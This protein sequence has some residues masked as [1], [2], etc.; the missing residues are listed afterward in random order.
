VKKDILTISRVLRVLKEIGIDTNS[1]NLGDS[2][3]TAFIIPAISK[4]EIVNKIHGI[5]K[6]KDTPD[7]PANAMT[8]FFMY[9]ADEITMFEEEIK[10]RK[11]HVINIGLYVEDTEEELAEKAKKLKDIYIA[12]IYLCNYVLLCKN[13]IVPESLTLYEALVV[14]EDITCSDINKI[15][16]ELVAM[17]EAD[18]A[19][20]AKQVR[21]TL[22]YANFYSFALDI[23]NDVDEMYQSL[24]KKRNQR[25]K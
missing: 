16:S 17:I 14:I 13:G 23:Y 10:R 4:P 19:A 11:E 24:E 12:D 9:I 15:T 5:I 6:D 3:T 2:V 25:I 22:K 8:S 7:S 1:L 18:N 21:E 20:F